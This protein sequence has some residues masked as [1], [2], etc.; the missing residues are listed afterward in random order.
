[1]NGTGRAF[2]K[3]MEPV[4]SFPRAPNSMTRRNTMLGF[5]VGLGVAVVAGAARGLIE[6]GI[7]AAM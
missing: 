7:Q 4:D 5:L 3:G 1:V 6:M 2:S